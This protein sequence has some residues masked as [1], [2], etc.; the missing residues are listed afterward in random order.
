[1]FF[2]LARGVPEAGLVFAAAMMLGV[3]TTLSLV[4]LFSVFM[5]DGLIALMTRHGTSLARLTRLL[6]AASGLLLIAISLGE[7]SR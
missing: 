1:M 3:L 7:L 2:A 4:A 5:R 6:D